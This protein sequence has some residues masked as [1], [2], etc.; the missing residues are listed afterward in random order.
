[1][2][3]KRHFLKFDRQMTTDFEEYFAS[4]KEIYEPI[5]KKLNLKIIG[6]ES[7]F[8]FCDLDTNTS[9]NISNTLALKLKK[10][11]DET[12]KKEENNV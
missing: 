11:I 5:E 3:R 10:L 1:M 12:D 8:L 4:W 6:F 9:V 7:G 2:T